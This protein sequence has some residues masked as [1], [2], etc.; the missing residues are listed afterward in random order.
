MTEKN[1]N[2]LFY[3]C[4]LI[5]FIARKTLNKRGKVVEALSAA[6]IRKQ[7]Q[8]ADVNHSLSFEQVSDEVIEA[9][10]IENGDFDTISN[11]EYSIPSCTD[12]GKLY[13]ILIAEC[14]EEGKEAEELEKIFKS[15]ISDEISDFRTGLYYQNP[16]YLKW[17]YKEG[18]LLA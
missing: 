17:S 18:C 7:L 14:S 4:S 1:R 5:E 2:N 8:D 9:Y 15:F 11:C 13:T 3:V 6:G 16:D 12:I 10:H